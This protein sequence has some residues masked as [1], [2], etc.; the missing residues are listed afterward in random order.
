M[1]AV[2]DLDDHAALV[3]ALR[4]PRAWPGVSAAVE[5]VETHI[6]SVLLAGEHACKLK[7]PVR[8]SFLDFS[9][10]ERRRHFCEEE[11][12]INRRTA[13]RL[14]LGVRPI[15]GSIESPRLGS[16]GSEGE[17]I[18][19]CVW[20]R[21]FDSAHTLDRLAFAGALTDA[22]IDAQAIAALHAVAAPVP[23][24]ADYGSAAT[25]RR[26]ALRNLDDLRAD[27]HAA[28][29][30]GR[31]DALLA[32]TGHEAARLATAIDA[33]RAAGRVRE[34]HGDLHLGNA[35]LID[36]APLLFDALEFDPEL[37]FIDVGSDVAFMFMD[38][39]DHELPALGWRLLDGWL[40]A[41]GD[42]DAAPLLRFYAV[43]RALVRARVAQ[44]RAQQG[45]RQ[46]GGAGSTRLSRL[47]QHVSYTHY[48]ALAERLAQ[49]PAPALVVM[50]GLSGSGKSTAAAAIARALGALRIRSDVERKRLAGLD[51][52]AR[53]DDAL[54][55]PAMTARTYVRMQALAGMLLD[56]GLSVVVDAAALRAAE[57]SALATVARRR[58]LRVV[59]VACEAPIGVLAARIDARGRT[60]ADPSD[61][62]RAV[63]QRQVG[64]REPRAADE[65][66]HWL[67]DT[68]VERAQLQ[69][70]C[71]VLAQRLL[72]RA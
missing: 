59:V 6:S 41:S 8:F 15:V 45:N 9:T 11:L 52:Q 28:A 60:G 31:L 61:A 49:P 54:Y 50:S 7:K 44:L 13:A 33:R 39:L 14:Y 71:A 1:R 26:W 21:R 56:A 12:R 27:A 58:G 64:W 23:P 65:P 62:T 53:G 72:T 2:A 3:A 29:D 40:Q 24:D 36:G 19:Y 34:C 68:A 46:G 63:L 4:D 5:L 70:A 16:E 51:P 69:Q 25:A 10:L 32:W 17:A 42:W 38:L 37:R 18:E 67:L 57:R 47:R 35:V 66:E 43:Y 48:L 55:A 22:H 20:M 30:R